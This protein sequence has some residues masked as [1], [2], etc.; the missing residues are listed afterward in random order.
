MVPACLPFK[1]FLVDKNGKLVTTKL[2]HID[3]ASRKYSVLVYRHF[4][5]IKLLRSPQ[6]PSLSIVFERLCGLAVTSITADFG[7]MDN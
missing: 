6:N 2:F 4:K 5:R 7:P 1:N 3:F